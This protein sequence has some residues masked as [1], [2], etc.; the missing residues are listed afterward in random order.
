MIPGMFV[1][2][3]PSFAGPQLGA[4][5]RLLFLI[6]RCAIGFAVINAPPAEPAVPVGETPTRLAVLCVKQRL[7]VFTRSGVFLKGRL[8]RLRT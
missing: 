1:C 4:F 2:L 5:S 7:H 6:Y 8:S 3:V